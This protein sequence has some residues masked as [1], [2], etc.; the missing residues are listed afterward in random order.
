MFAAQHI[1]YRQTAAFSKIVLNY[2]DEAQ[3]LQPFYSFYPHLEGIKSAIEKKEKQ[4]LD[5]PLLVKALQQQYAAIK[6]TEA[7]QQNIQAL[8]SANT[9]TICTAH[10]PN[11]FTGPLYFIYKILHVIKLAIYLKEQLPAYHFVPVYYMGSED[12]DFAELNHTYVNGKRIEWTKEQSGSVGRMMVDKTLIQLIDEL[13]GQLSVEAHGQEVIQLLRR[14]YANGKTIQAATFEMVNELYGKWGLIV[15]IPDTPSLKSQMAKIFSDDLFQNVPSGLVQKTSQKLE[16][17]YTAQAHPRPINLFYLKDGIRERIEREGNGFSV[18]NSEITFTEE[19]LKNELERHPERF[20]PNVILRGLYQETIL[21]NVAFIGGGG[22]LAYWLQLKELFEYYHTP[23]PVLVLRNSFLIV[24]K[25]WQEGIGRLGLTAPDFFLSENELMK[26]LVQKVS[27]NAVSLNG[28]FEKAEE[29]FEQI[30][31]QAAA[32]DPTLS[33]HVAA[34]K[35]R[36]LKNLQELEKKML[37]AEKRKFIDQQRQIQ[38]IMGTL[39]PA[40]G[41]QERVENISGFYA[42]WGS[43]FIDELYNASLSLEQKFTILNAET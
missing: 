26:V 1:P 9:F 34:I 13:E 3:A 31:N 15:L 7:V 41:L 8:S 16:E 19:A 42:K 18:L 39:F 21:P 20:S 17:H 10:Q 27:S 11:L 23:F 12:A 28:T 38:K 22:E 35:A 43:R 24:E 14:C 2:L 29:L 6:T 33:K 30:K 4:R 25:K 5:R 36:S 40:N 32:I 37:R